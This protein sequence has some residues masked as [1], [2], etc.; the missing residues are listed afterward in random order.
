MKANSTNIT[1]VLDKSG[2]MEPIRQDTIGGFNRFLEEQQKVP[3]EATLT[4]V[5]FD[6]EYRPKSSTPIKSFRT[7]TAEDYA[8]QGNT[9]LYGA[10][11]CAMRETGERLKALGE[12]QRP[13]KVIFVIITDGEEN[14]SHKHE[15]SRSHNADTVKADIERQQNTYKWQFVF[16]G[17]NQDAILNASRMGIHTANAMNYTDNAEGTH[18]L[19]ASMSANVRSFRTGTARNMSWSASQRKEQERAKHKVH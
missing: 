11:G 5:F 15:W 9:C 7:L 3:G 19:Y 17:A 16:I 2:S 12:E 4:T 18:K 8:P 6:H 14:S 10:V 13:E 1:I